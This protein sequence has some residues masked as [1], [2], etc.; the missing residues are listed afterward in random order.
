MPLP[1]TPYYERRL[2]DLRTL[3]P[4]AAALA[5]RI[6]LDL[7]PQML[8]TSTEML[9]AQLLDHLQEVAE[10][11][12]R[13]VTRFWDWLNAVVEIMKGPGFV[14]LRFAALL[15]SPLRPSTCLPS[16]GLS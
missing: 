2:R 8:A 14:E 3:S 12:T 9:E 4:A 5:E 6:A 1:V 15:H 13:C 11:Q 16:K 7:Q 10:Q